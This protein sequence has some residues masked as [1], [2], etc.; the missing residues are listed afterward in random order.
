MDCKIISQFEDLP[1]ELLLLI[2]RYLEIYE[3]LNSFTC[4]NNRLSQTM[5]E[6]SRKIDLNL[7]PLKLM[8]RFIN[9]IF[10][11]ISSNVR[12]LILNDNFEY[13]PIDISIFNNLESI[14]FLNNFC[15]DFLI[16]IKEM[17]LDLVSV[18]LQIDLLKELF[19]SNKYSNLKSLSL[20][21]FHGFTFSNIQLINST[22]IEN[23]TINLKN[24]IDLFELLHLL[25]LSIKKLNIHILYN[26]SF[27]CLSSLKLL[28]LDKLKYFHLKTTFEDSIK[29]KELEKLI[30]ES[31]SYLEYLSIETLTRD[32]NYI[33]GYQWKIFL[34]KLIYLK[35]FSCSIRYRFKINEDDDQI[36]IEQKLLNSFSTNFWLNEKKWFINTYSTISMADQRFSNINKH[37]KLYLYTIPYPYSFI[38]VTIDINTTRSTIDQYQIKFDNFNYFT[39]IYSN[40]RHLYYDGEFIPIKF[41][42]LKNILGQF[43]LINELKLDRLIIDSSSTLSNQIKFPHL[44]KLIIY[45]NDEKYSFNMELF[46]LSSMY[47]LR[48]IRIPHILLP[49]YSQM[50]KQLQTLVLTEC[51]NLNFDFIHKYQHLRILKLFLN[52]F[53]RLLENNAKLLNN[54]I[55]SIYTNNQTMESLQLM[56][57]GVNQKKVKTFQEQFNF[58]TIDYLNANYDGKSLT[59]QRSKDYF[60]QLF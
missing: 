11:N 51:R 1:D 9:E 17:K 58:N 20:S 3:I 39:N 49:H 54:L 50:P 7:I 30:I 8:N 57:P 18:N 37:G 25:S 59:I 6:F 53:D 48:Y 55:K 23:L 46:N 41:D 24:N 13:F 2:C 12:S 32:E 5:N 21:S 15:K 35:Q 47:N 19:S 10:V 40:V 34:E 38:D 43:K 22:E 42:H 16:N 56:C 45:E 27:K 60:N 52:N 4:L 29:F 31:F 14:H 33:N 44:N 36:Q 26:G 28:K